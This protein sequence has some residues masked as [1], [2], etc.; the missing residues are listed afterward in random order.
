MILSGY[1]DEF[2][3]LIENWRSV[4]K[5]V[6]WTDVKDPKEDYISKAELFVPK[7]AISPFYGKTRIVV[8]RKV[9]IQMR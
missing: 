2:D 4:Y 1:E 7:K 9:V 6:D 5:S 8:N 3:E